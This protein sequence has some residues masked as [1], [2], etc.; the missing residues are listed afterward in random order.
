MFSDKAS[1]TVCLL[2]A[3]FAERMRSDEGHLFLAR[4]TARFADEVLLFVLRER[5]VG[6]GVLLDAIRTDG[7]LAEVEDLIKRIGLM[8]LFAPALSGHTAVH[9]VGVEESVFCFTE[10]HGFPP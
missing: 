9:A 2:Y 10:I 8:T 5:I 6:E 3:F 7:Y 4:I 1:F